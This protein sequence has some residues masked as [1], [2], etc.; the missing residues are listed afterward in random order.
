MA[1]KNTLERRQTFGAVVIMVR[2]DEAM[3][4]FHL[5]GEKGN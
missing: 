5:Q 4:E 1:K 3:G 2:Q